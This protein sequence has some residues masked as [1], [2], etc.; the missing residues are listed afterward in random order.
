MANETKKTLW[1]SVYS[2]RSGIESVD[3]PPKLSQDDIEKR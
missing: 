1:T 3:T 2:D